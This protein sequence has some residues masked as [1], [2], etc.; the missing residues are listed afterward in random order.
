M[1]PL[2]RA[3]FSFSIQ[4]WTSDCG[5]QFPEDECSTERCF[6]RSDQ[7]RSCTL[8][9]EQQEIAR[10]SKS[11]NYPQRSRMWLL[12][13]GRTT[14]RMPGVRS[15][16][17]SFV[18]YFNS[19]RATSL[20]IMLWSPQF[21]PQLALSLYCKFI[22][23]NHA[24]SPDMYISKAKKCIRVWYSDEVEGHH[25]ARHIRVLWEGT[26][27]MEVHAGALTSAS[28]APVWRLYHRFLNRTMQ[29]QLGIFNI[30]GV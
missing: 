18:G 28:A 24:P 19:T 16:Y 27:L 10:Q 12:I 3:T 14:N 20:T 8:S 11:R 21:S 23:E 17:I 7:F 29:H 25:R 22:L 15:W 13:D 2:I 9:P 6:C 5:V 4:I 1:D 30:Q 26:F